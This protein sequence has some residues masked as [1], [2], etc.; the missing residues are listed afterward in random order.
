MAEPS[1]DYIE[2]GIRQAEYENL[3][4][5]TDWK[6]VNFVIQT[7]LDRMCDD[8]HAEFGIREPTTQTVLRNYE[9]V[10]GNRVFKRK[11]RL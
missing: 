9:R 8:L 3:L 7:W 6:V 5:T 2:R 11:G 10:K 4:A 1:D